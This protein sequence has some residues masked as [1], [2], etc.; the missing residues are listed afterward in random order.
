MSCYGQQG[1]ICWYVLC[2]QAPDPECLFCFH[3]GPIKG[4][5]V[6]KHSYLMATTTLDR[7]F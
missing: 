3:A 1:L 4:L 2:V 7:K 6:S 5:D